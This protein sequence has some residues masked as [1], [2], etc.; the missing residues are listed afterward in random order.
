MVTFLLGMAWA[1][2]SVVFDAYAIWLVWGWHG[3][4]LGLP[5]LSLARAAGVSSLASLFVLRVQ[6]SDGKAL[7]KGIE[8]QDFLRRV[9]GSE[10]ATEEEIAAVE[11][12]VKAR[13]KRET[14]VLWARRGLW[15]CM[16]T[17]LVVVAKIAEV[18]GR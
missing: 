18:M 14:H 17:V 2:F 16:I 9:K 15:L 1:L 8:E 11:E 10:D 13:D 6:R 7:V 12:G 5:A 3:V 4:A